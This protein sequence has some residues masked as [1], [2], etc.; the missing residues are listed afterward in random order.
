MKFDIVLAGIGGQGVLSLSTI[1]AAGADA[2]GL[3]AKQS[4]THGMAQ[5]GG[6]VVA[7]LR[8]ADG[9]IA[10]ELVPRGAASMILAMEPLEG[11]RQLTFLAE[12][13]V[14]V[15]SANPTLNIPDYPQIEEV[16][17]QIEALPRSLVVD[18]DR[19]ARES[20]SLLTAN[21]VLIGAASRFLPF[22]PDTLERCIERRFHSK[23]ERI[24]TANL[25]A[26]R[27]GRAAGG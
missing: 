6:A 7:H 27:A 2:E 22:D 4:E 9:P 19:L 13:G 15:A 25:K 11:L 21:V 10:S 24:L 23:G 20:G 17:R 3:V 12:D 26:F 14:L 16:L 1:I 18:A 5:R 8:L